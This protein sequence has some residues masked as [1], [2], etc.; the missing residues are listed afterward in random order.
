MT[1]PVLYFPDKD[2]L[3]PQQSIDFSAEN[4]IQDVLEIEVVCGTLVNEIR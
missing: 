4:V 2:S 3:C 1:L